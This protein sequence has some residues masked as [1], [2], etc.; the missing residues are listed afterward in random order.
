MGESGFDLVREAINGIRQLR[1]DYAIPPGQRINASLDV[2]SAGDTGFTDAGIFEEEGAF[3]S[4]IAKTDLTPHQGSE[5]GASI[6]LS[7]GSRIR[8]ALE[9]VI[10]I[11]KECRKARTELEKLTAQLDGLEARLGNPGFTDRAPA[12]VV[13][14]ERQKQ[15]DWTARKAQ[16]T[17][18]VA[19]LCGN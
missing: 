19:S 17:E 13:E 18:K 16:L 5:K 7:S 12:S 8:V 2:S 3:I 11:D 15:R 14:A 6:L 10:D 9:G 4:R 1:A